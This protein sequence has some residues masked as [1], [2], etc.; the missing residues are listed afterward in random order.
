MS[1]PSL[2]VASPSP[3]KTLKE[4][5]KKW[6]KPLLSA[7]W[8]LLP[9]VIVEKQDVL[10]LNANDVNILM[11]IIARWWYKER[12]P[13]PSIGQIAKVMGVHRST[14]QRRIRD[15]EDRGLLERIP[16]TNRSRGQLNN[17]YDLSGLIRKATPLA[18]ELI[19]EKEKAKKARELKIVRQ[20]DDE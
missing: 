3:E 14:V 6:G 18:K 16:R 5:E 4:N 13:F 7:G 12:L 11:H 19:K 2:A 17:A 20:E 8:S 10:G 9:T 15:M 1:S